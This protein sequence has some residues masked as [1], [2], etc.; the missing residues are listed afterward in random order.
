VEQVDGGEKS[1]RRSESSQNLNLNNRQK[2]RNGKKRNGTGM[3]RGT[4]NEGNIWNV[5]AGI[6]KPKP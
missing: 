4:M 5:T 1:G 3:Q 6:P 2:K